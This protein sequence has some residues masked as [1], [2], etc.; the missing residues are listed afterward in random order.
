MTADQLLQEIE[1]LPYAARIH[2]MVNLGR[3]AVSDPQLAT[4]LTTLEKGDFYPRFLAIYAC[5]GSRD[6]EHVLRSLADPSRLIRSVAIDLAPLTCNEEQLRQALAIVPHDGR[7][8]LLAK[9]RHHDYQELIDAFLEQSGQ[10][11]DPQLLHLLPYGSPTLVRQYITYLQPA[12]KV[13]NWR[14]LTRHHPTIAFELLQA[15]AEASTQLDLQ[16]VAFVNG[17]LPIL[18]EKQPDQ[19]LILIE[20][21]G[22]AVPLSRFHLQP[23]LVQRPI[24]FAD[25]VLQNSGDLG[26]LD[27]SP[28][29]HKLDDE[30]LFALQEKRPALLEFSPPERWFQRIPSERRAAIYTI[31][32]P[33]WRDDYRFGR[34]PANIVALLPRPLREQE[35]RRLLALPSQALHPE[36]RLVYAAFLPWDEAHNVLDPFLHDPGERVRT[37]ALQTLVQTTRYEPDR[38]PE[39]LATVRDHLHE[40]DPVCIAMLESL[41]EL[42]RWIWRAEH[43]ENMEHI[44]QGVL[45][46]FDASSF[47]IGELLLLIIRLLECAPEW[48]ATQF[49]LVAQ[50]RGIR[51]RYGCIDDRLSDAAVRQLGPA[52]RPVLTSWAEKGNEEML[53]SLLFVFRKRVRVFEELF[54]ALELIFHNNP[55]FDFSNQILRTIA[56][57]RPARAAQLIPA[58][59]QDN[60]N[61]ITYPAVLAYLLKKRQDLLTPFLKHKKYHDLFNDLNPEKGHRR[62]RHGTRPLTRGYARWTAR[63]QISFARTLREVILV[64]ADDHAQIGRAMGRLFSLPAI[65]DRHRLALTKNAQPVVRDRA[66]VLL[67]RLDDPT[68]VLPTLEA[69]LQDERAGRAIYALRPCLLTLPPQ[70]ALT[71]L[72]AI[73][74]TRVTIAKEVVR[75]LGDLPGEEAFQELLALDAQELHRDVRAALLRALGHHLERDEA[76]RILEREVRSADKII[77]LSAARLSISPPLAQAYHARKRFRYAGRNRYAQRHFFWFSEWN[78]ITMT[79]LSGEHLALKAQQRLMHLFALLL[80]RPESDVRAAVLRGCTRLPAADE[81]HM[82]LRHMLKA[83]D[84]DDEEICTAAA[85]AIFG[86]CVASD[87]SA[88]SQ[89]IARLLP[90]RRALMGILPV[91]QQTLALSRYQLIPVVRAIIVALAADPLTVGLRIQLAI[92]SLPWDEIATMLAEAA[93]AGI[94]HAD[95]LQ[96]TCTMLGTVI[97]GYGQAGRPDSKEMVILE[98][99][100]ATSQDERLRR[101]ALAAL[102]THAE[103]SKGWNSELRARLESYR[104]DPSILVATAAQFTLLPHTEA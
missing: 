101:I 79:H 104:A 88:I 5:F 27:F 32:A 17:I 94:L 31:F 6:G 65:P 56:R 39:V 75:L 64:G 63:Q 34:I 76:W 103:E 51:F 9:L 73:P 19:A 43:L 47:T 81:E 85:S 26:E 22:H 54:D 67:N 25:L 102:I 55:S 36:E 90:N 57:Y 15:K 74:F 83:M 82:L 8:S 72:H 45:H 97:G 95:A 11:H 16:L 93:A 44:I 96:Q 48:S 89:A 13:V 41:A 24:Q 69:A 84:A 60:R 80:A 40:P 18:A 7:R 3:V 86:T 14:R 46:T 98:K 78:S 87:A 71:I 100:L 38:L 10:K 68:Q 1:T 29:A 58:L 49:A 92:V 12:L 66:L 20:T 28:V 91:L 61:W 2:Y 50:A 59:I 70:Q 62:W 30:R 99:K 33:Y 21:L 35:G 42:P 4:T 37:A 52:L 23:L 77:A 53:R